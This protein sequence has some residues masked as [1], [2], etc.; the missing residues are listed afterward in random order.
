MKKLQKP[1]K[2]SAAL[3]PTKNTS[4]I[5]P[6]A[7]ESTTRGAE[8]KSTKA[9]A[10]PTPLELIEIAQAIPGGVWQRVLQEQ[11]YAS[12]KRDLL[13]V[14]RKARHIWQLAQGVC[15]SRVDE[16]DGRAAQE[17]KIAEWINTFKPDT[18]KVAA[19]DAANFL[20]WT[21]RELSCAWRRFVPEEIEQNWDVNEEFL[22]L[23]KDRKDGHARGKKAAKTRRRREKTKAHQEK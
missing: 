3:T 22:L 14:L 10:N 16:Y 19:K 20:G 8:G 4:G 15:G 17:D 12:Q 7:K 9:D 2:P 23:L 18:K 21:Q 6:K 1:T 5:Q 11:L 13:K